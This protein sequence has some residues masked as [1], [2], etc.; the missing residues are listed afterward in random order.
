MVE[1]LAQIQLHLRRIMRQCRKALQVKLLGTVTEL[2]N[3]PL[4]LTERLGRAVLVFVGLV[5]HSALRVLDDGFALSD[6]GPTSSL[7]LIDVALKRISYSSLRSFR[8]WTVASESSSTGPP[9]SLNDVCRMT[10][11]SS[12]FQHVS[13]LSSG[14]TT[15]I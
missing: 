13:I 6:A 10:K 2:S 3:H 14:P 9:V 15:I 11:C 1:R 12:V 5:S 7:K 4:L 8:P